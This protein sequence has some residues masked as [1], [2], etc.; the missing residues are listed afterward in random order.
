MTVLTVSLGHG[1]PDVGPDHRDDV[2][3]GEATSFPVERISPL[4]AET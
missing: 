2:L 3:L 4:A 1:R